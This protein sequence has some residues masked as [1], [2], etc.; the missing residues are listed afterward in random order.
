MPPKTRARTV[1]LIQEI[2]PDCV[3]LEFVGA[4]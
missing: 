4:I 1:T 3:R 2:E